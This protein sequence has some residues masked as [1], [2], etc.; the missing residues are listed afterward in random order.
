[1]CISS[2]A[3][4]DLPELAHRI[5]S[6]WKKLNFQEKSAWRQAFFWQLTNHKRNIDTLVV[7]KET[8]LSAAVKTRNNGGQVTLKSAGGAINSFNYW[9]ATWNIYIY[10]VENNTHFW[11]L[12]TVL[13]LCCYL[14][15]SLQDINRPRGSGDSEAMSHERCCC[16]LSCYR[17][18]MCA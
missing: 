18:W 12:I 1:M 10:W 15:Q 17:G 3:R 14:Y 11:R 9:W 8:R 5:R 16:L 4:V 7:M 2:A 6:I 13:L